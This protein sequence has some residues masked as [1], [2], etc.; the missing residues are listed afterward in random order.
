VSTFLLLGRKH[1]FSLKTV[2]PAAWHILKMLLKFAGGFC[3]FLMV[4]LPCKLIVTYWLIDYLSET[5]SG[6]QE[7]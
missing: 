5:G 3:F 1:H 2:F 6:Q 7:K 4:D